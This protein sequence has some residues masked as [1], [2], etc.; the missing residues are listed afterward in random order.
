MKINEEII[1]A[2]VVVSK[3]LRRISPYLGSVI[4]K[5]SA[6]KAEGN[7]DLC[8]DIVLNASEKMLKALKEPGKMLVKGFKPKQT[9]AYIRGL[10]N[11]AY[12]ETR[13][14]YFEGDIRCVKHKDI[15]TVSLANVYKEP[16]E[17]PIFDIAID[18]EED[19]QRE[20]SYWD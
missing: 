19:I 5:L 6:E 11:F 14:F 4:L 16:G 9:I 13:S 17:E 18:Y 20:E 2:E 8:G 15:N 7:D 12:L 10:I 1:Q 3:K